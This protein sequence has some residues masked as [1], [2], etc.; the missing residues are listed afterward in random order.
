MSHA[1]EPHRD[2]L[3]AHAN[4]FTATC[5]ALAI[6]GCGFAVGL[7]HPATKRLAFA[8]DS[9]CRC[10]RTWPRNSHYP[11]V[12]YR[13]TWSFF[14]FERAA[15]FVDCRCTWYSLCIEQLFNKG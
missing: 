14:R 6:P 15:G 1:Y 3:L 10:T 11:D 13:H 9:D 5:N 2:S 7:R 4:D 12:R 8:A